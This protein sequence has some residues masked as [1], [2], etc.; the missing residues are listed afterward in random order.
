LKRKLGRTARYAIGIKELKDYFSGRA[1]LKQVKE[2]MKLNTRHYAK[3]QLTWFRKDKRIIW[4]KVGKN[5][6]I[7][8]VANK[9]W[10]ELY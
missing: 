5:E 9:I 2:R 10:K 4:V 7:K 6:K 8:D 3:R 1:D